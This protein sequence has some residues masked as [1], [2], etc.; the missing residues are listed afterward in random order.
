MSFG[1]EDVDRYIVVYK[2]DLGP[3]DDE[4]AARRNGDE[5]NEKTA[6]KYAQMVNIDRSN[7]EK[8]KNII[9]IWMY[10]NYRK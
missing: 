2:K 5:W 3:S 9:Y 8:Y 7:S 4:I 10:A 6:A 1:V